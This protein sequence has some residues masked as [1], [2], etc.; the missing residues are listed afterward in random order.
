[1]YSTY[2]CSVAYKNKLNGLRQVRHARVGGGALAVCALD[3]NRVTTHRP[4]GVDIAPAVSDDVGPGE[5]DV[6][7]TRGLEQ[8]AWPRLATVAAVRLVVWADANVLD[9]GVFAQTTL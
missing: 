1:M 4:A 5:V 3:E 6:P 2:C 7:L 8:H 9:E